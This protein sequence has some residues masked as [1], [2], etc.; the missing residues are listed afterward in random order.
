MF[1]MRVKK[2]RGIAALFPVILVLN[3]CG[4]RPDPVA[5]APAD[6]AWVTGV[7]VTIQGFL[8]G[9][10]DSGLAQSI[11]SCVAQAPTAGTIADELHAGWQVQV[12]VQNIYIPRPATEVGVTLLY[13]EHVEAFHWHRALDAERPAALCGTVSRLTEQDW[14][15]ISGADMVSS[16]QG[17][18]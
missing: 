16:T 14:T 18:S 3:A 7:P 1:A 6:P 11:T 2:N 5:G 10:S 4:V 15:T 13:D 8:P 12:N 9:Y 17:E